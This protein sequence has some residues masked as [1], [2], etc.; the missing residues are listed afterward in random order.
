MGVYVVVRSDHTEF[1][2]H[3]VPALLRM[4]PNSE[5]ASSDTHRR[6][7]SEWPE[8]GVGTSIHDGLVCIRRYPIGRMGMPL[9]RS[10]FETWAF[11]RRLFVSRRSFEHGTGEV[12]MV[13]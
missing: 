9:L 2:V 7:I 12:G 5:G 11:R 10:G 1:E 13:P 3:G 4:R 8:V 6:G